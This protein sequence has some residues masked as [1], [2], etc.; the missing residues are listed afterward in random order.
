M[1]IWMGNFISTAS[2]C[3]AYITLY[4]VYYDE[5]LYSPKTGA[6][7]NMIWLVDYNIVPVGCSYLRVS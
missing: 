3:I 4:I 7:L 6:I 2:L 1:W 5:N